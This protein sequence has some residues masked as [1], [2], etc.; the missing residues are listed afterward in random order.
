VDVATQ[1][2]SVQPTNGRNPQYFFRVGGTF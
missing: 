2:T 1:I